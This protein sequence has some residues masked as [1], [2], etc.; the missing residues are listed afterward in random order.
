MASG[1]ATLWIEIA[2][3]YYLPYLSECEGTK[4]RGIN[5]RINTKKNM[6]T[7]EDAPEKSV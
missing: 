5:E 1:S 3:A 4:K 2:S 6:S 7:P